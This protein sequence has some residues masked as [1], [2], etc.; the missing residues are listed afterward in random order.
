MRTQILNSPSWILKG[1]VTR[2]IIALLLV[3][4][5]LPVAYLG[6]LGTYALFWQ[7]YAFSPDSIPFILAP[8]FVVFG[9]LGTLLSF[10]YA[11]LTLAAL[12]IF[13][14]GWAV[15][16]HPFSELLP[17]SFLLWV[18][19]TMFAILCTNLAWLV[20]SLRGRLSL[21]SAA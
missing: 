15:T 5:A 8:A 21:R 18:H 17:R 13:Y 2:I 16:F 9:A 14:L 10:R 19:V 12:T 1:M 6:M 4:L 3:L 7:G 20:W 11:L